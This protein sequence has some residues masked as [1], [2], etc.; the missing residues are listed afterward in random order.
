M[1][2]KHISKSFPGPSGRLTVFRDFSITL[3]EQEITVILGASG[4]GKTTLLNLLARFIT[5]ESGTITGNEG[6]ISYLFQEPRLLPWRTV[7]RNISL[8][9][10]THVHDQTVLKQRTSHVL[11]LVGL[12][13]FAG[14]YPHEL[15]GGMRQRV[16]IARAFAFPSRLLLMDEPFQAL[17]LDVKLSLVRAFTRSWEEDPRTA[18]FVTHDIQEALMVADTIVVFTPRPAQVRSMRRLKTPR[19]HRRLGEGELAEVEQQVIADVLAKS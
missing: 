10:E 7:A 16:S 4:C 12:E 18:V 3:P 9:L 19:Q 6:S 13:S 1:E 8:V 11:S 14:F 15:S 17:D 5:P 2:I